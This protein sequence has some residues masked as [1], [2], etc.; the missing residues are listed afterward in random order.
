MQYFI[1]AIINPV[2]G[3]FI[4]QP[5]YIPPH[6]QT[7]ALKQASMDITKTKSFF[8]KGLVVENGNGSI[9]SYIG[10]VI[11]WISVAV[12]V[13]TLEY[14]RAKCITA[15]PVSPRYA[16]LGI[17]PIA[18]MVNASLS[19]TNMV[20]RNPRVSVLVRGTANLL[21]VANIAAKALSPFL[22]LAIIYS[23]RTAAL[24]HPIL[25]CT[26]LV[27][28]GAE[29]FFGFRQIRTLSRGKYVHSIND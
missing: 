2:I 14:L 13:R 8:E 20:K 12:S 5:Q 17:I 4:A 25:F 19:Q 24:A 9:P 1:P 26:S 10:A 27:F 21:S 18:Y 15:I 23:L 29:I 3:T 28:T 11:P 7:D 6:L 22:S 16:L